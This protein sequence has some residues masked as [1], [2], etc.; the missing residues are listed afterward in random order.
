METT[1]RTYGTGLAPLAAPP[2]SDELPSILPHFHQTTYPYQPRAKTQ[3][4][5]T[6]RDPSGRRFGLEKVRHAR[7]CDSPTGVLVIP[8]GL[9]SPSALLSD[10]QERSGAAG[11]LGAT[12]STAGPGSPSRD[13]GV[14]GTSGVLKGS[15]TTSSA[16]AHMP[17][18]AAKTMMLTR[19]D[20]R[21]AAAAPSLGSRDSG[22]G[23]FGVSG[24]AG[25]AT[26]VPEPVTGDTVSRTHGQRMRLSPADTAVSS[27]GQR[28]RCTHG[29]FFVQLPS[30]LMRAPEGDSSVRGC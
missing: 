1:N 18:A 29:S 19:R 6:T 9:T 27:A 25:G 21:A 26:A 23:A 7:R 20:G 8:R 22:D 16:S 17:P 11:S 15:W 24:A 3:T 14:L 5:T 28:G 2:P 4:F 13:G 12:G 10:L 30:L